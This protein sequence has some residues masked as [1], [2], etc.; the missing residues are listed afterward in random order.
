MSN[1]KVDRGQTE[2]ITYAWSGGTPNYSGNIIV[3]NSVAI[4]ANVLFTGIS[5]TSNTLSFTVPPGATGMYTISANVQDSATT[6]ESNTLSNTLTANTAPTATQ[7]T[8]STKT[9]DIGQNAIISTTLS[10]GTGPFTANLV[11]S[12]NRGVANSVTDIPVGRTANL[13]FVPTYSGAF[14]FNIVITD[15]GTT[16]PYVF[17]APGNSVMTVDPAPTATSLTPSNAVLDLGQ[18][19]AYDVLLSGGTG[20]FTANLIYVSGP[21]GATVNGITA[22]NVIQSL[23][24]QVDGTITFS[25]FN[26]FSTNGLY[27]F[28]VIATDTGTSTPYVF[29]S[30]SNTVNVNPALVAPTITSPTAANTLDVGRSI[31]IS[32]SVASGGTGSYSYA[33]SVA[34]GS[35][36][37]GFTSTTGT[38]FT[39]TPNSA[40]TSCEF[41]V[42]A[43]DTGT[44]SPDTAVSSPTPSITVDPA[45]AGVSLTVSNSIIDVGQ[46]ETIT[47]TWSGGTP[48]YTGNIVVANSVGTLESVHFSGISTTSNTLSFTVPKG[49][50]GSYAITANVFDSASTTESNTL[51]NTLVAN[52]IPTLIVTP[53]TT[54]PVYG[55]SVKFTIEVLNGS[56]PTTVT[57]YN[58]TTSTRRSMG[59]VVVAN[60]GATNTIIVSPAAIDTFL[61]RANATDSANYVFNSTLITITSHGSGSGGGGGGGL[62]SALPSATTTIAPGITTAVPSG[63][64]TTIAPP[65]PPSPAPTTTVLPP[66]VVPTA[67]TAPSVPAAAAL[68]WYYNPVY[69]GIIAAVTI[70]VVAVGVLA[71]RASIRKRAMGR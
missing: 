30:I 71:V 56:G 29:N 14:T 18:G 23:T 57:L 19:E 65:S 1:P 66:P 16:T 50:I 28:N 15:T 17:N 63:T 21:P 54:T 44:S 43:T 48:T 32:S 53:N 62:P 3:S 59:S 2:T 41:E 37:P 51:T 58:V 9:L 13:G 47:Y 34:S 4:I 26:S 39:Y 10:G 35:S 36:C 61:F 64:A 70:V 22:G 24:G 27:T 40:T 67:S 45:L 31:T 33:W 12:N 20:S 6:P 69:L 11:Y 38:S 8:P 25:S 46:H 52:A 68:P 55:S 5:K 7:V 42:T 49:A 60:S